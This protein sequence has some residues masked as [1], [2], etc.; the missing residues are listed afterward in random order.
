MQGQGVQARRGGLSAAAW[1]ECSGG[2]GVAGG[3]GKVSMKGGGGSL[4]NEI[5]IGAQSP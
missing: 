2:A 5:L 1:T 4:R 3:R